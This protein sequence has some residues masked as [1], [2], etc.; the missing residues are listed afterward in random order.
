MILLGKR[1]DGERKHSCRDEWRWT[2]EVPSFLCMLDYLH[3]YRS[4]TRHAYKWKDIRMD[5][6]INDPIPMVIMTMITRC[7]DDAWCACDYES[8]TY[9][10][11]RQRHI[12]E[13]LFHSFF[14]YHKIVRLILKTGGNLTIGERKEPQMVSLV[15][16][17]PALGEV[18]LL[19]VVLKWN[20]RSR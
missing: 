20:S 8:S 2:E 3:E 4:A 9:E 12:C 7:H 5:M 16:I 18:F 14:L 6:M 1:E 13:P 19:S 10:I 15:V 17:N 11:I